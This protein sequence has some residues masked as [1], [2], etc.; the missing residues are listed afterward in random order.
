LCSDIG[1]LERLPISDEE[2]SQLYRRMAGNLRMRCDKMPTLPKE[3]NEAA[4]QQALTSFQ[5]QAEQSKELDDLM[6]EYE[7]WLARKADSLHVPVK[8]LKPRLSSEPMTPDEPEH[9]K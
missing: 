3:D 5:S 6:K 8:T 7:Q 2:S 9:S 4:L 1:A